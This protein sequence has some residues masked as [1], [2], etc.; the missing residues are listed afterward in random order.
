M[1]IAWKTLRESPS[2]AACT[3]SSSH[4][5][6]VFTRMARWSGSGPTCSGFRPRF[7]AFAA[8]SAAAREHLTVVLDDFGNPLW[9][10]YGIDVVPT[11]I[12]FEGGAAKTRRDGRAGVGL[13][14]KDLETL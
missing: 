6:L 9:D 3:A 14:E 13:T 10:A 2:R 8:R 7:E 12:V 11:V 1:Q 4:R 5:E